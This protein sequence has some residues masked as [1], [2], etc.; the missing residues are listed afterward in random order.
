[1]TGNFLFTTDLHIDKRPDLGNAPDGKNWMLSI[2][3]SILEQIQEVI[4]TYHV[5][6]F[7]HLGDLFEKKD[8]LPAEILIETKK[9]LEQFPSSCRIY[10]LMGNHDS[11]TGDYSLVSLFDSIE[12]IHETTPKEIDGKLFFF[13][14]FKRNWEDFKN[15]FEKGKLIPN[16]D[17]LCFHQSI[18]G[19]KYDNG[20]IITGE[21]LDYSSQTFKIFAGDIHTPQKIGDVQYLGCPYQRDFGETKT[22]YVYLV[23]PKGIIKPIQLNYPKFET[24][25][26]NDLSKTDVNG[27]FIRITGEI[28]SASWSKEEKE[29]TREK[30]LDLNANNVVYS[31]EKKTVAYLKDV[32]KTDVQLVKEYI[33]QNGG[34]RN[35]ERLE[36]IALKYLTG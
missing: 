8:K 2:G 32:T 26:V 35:K 31:L 14:P 5:T 25:N 17:F 30:L 11:L 20:Q 15:D 6:S 34:L 28:D 3:L 21:F 9:K 23:T 19:A 18:P 13:I 4:E 36:R 16:L 33:E 1:M 10:H 7:I 29:Q 27:K 22:K 12:V 24:I